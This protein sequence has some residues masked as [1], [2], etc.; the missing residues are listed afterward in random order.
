MKRSHIFGI[1]L[2]AVLIGAI[3]STLA[4]SST[5]ANLKEAQENVGEEFHVVGTLALEEGIEYNPIQSASETRFTLVDNEGRRGQVVLHKAKPQ[6]F[7]RAENLVLIGKANEAGVFH[8]TDV[9]MKCPSKYNE[10]GEFTQG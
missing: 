4:D 8:A 3:M 2:I 6:D 7:E 1:I 9:L 10:E 5:Y